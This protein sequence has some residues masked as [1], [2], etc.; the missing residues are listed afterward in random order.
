MNIDN[1]S[2][3]SRALYRA[4]ELERD[5]GRPLVGILVNTIDTMTDFLSSNSARKSF[6]A[7]STSFLEDSYKQVI[8]QPYR[9]LDAF[10]QHISIESNT[11]AVTSEEKAASDNETATESSEAQLRGRFIVT[12]PQDKMKK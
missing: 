3:I 1:P 2:E 8:K 12:V 7:Y 10:L 4:R 6:D 11:T 5:L 9:M